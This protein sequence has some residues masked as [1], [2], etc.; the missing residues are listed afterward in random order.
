MDDAAPTSPGRPGSRIERL[1]GEYAESHRSLANRLAQAIAL[2]LIVWSLLALLSALPFPAGWGVVPGIDWATIAVAVIVLG[3]LMLSWP[4]ALGLAAF[5][6]L[7]L[8]VAGAYVRWGELPIW[9]LAITTLL[10]GT[11]LHVVGGRLEG[12]PIS[13]AER[14]RSLLVGPA[15]LLALVYRLLGVRY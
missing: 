3:Y 13:P 1:I 15:W 9:Q 11:A 6:L 14:L 12:R 4:I 7:C 10:A 2:P 5:S 8:F